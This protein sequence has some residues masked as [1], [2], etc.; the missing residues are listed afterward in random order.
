MTPRR[1]AMQLKRLR[2]ARHLTQESL[3]KRAGI[4]REYLARLE[5]GR[6]DPSLSTLRV[7]AKALKV[8]VGE[9]LE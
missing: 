6:Q 3:A 1:F 8:T 7:L 4:S 5:G 9:L 2:I